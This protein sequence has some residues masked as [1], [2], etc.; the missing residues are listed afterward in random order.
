MTADMTDKL[1]NDYL[2][3]KYDRV[4]ADLDHLR[5][6]NNELQQELTKTRKEVVALRLKVDEMSEELRYATNNQPVKE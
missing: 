6:T 3:T 5:E 4:R 2:Q 1:A